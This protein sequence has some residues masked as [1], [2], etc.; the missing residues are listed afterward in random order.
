MKREPTRVVILNVGDQ[1]Y[2]QNDLAKVIT[3]FRAGVRSL[4]SANVVCECTVMNDDDAD[5]TAREVAGKHFDAFIVDYVSWHITPY[6]MRTL[7]DY[8]DVP[9]L[10]YG[11]GGWTDGT[12]KLIAPAAA[13][14]TTALTPVLKEFGFK[15]T[16]VNEKPD[17]GLKL[18][19]ID[20]FLRVVG[21]VK[22]VRH[23]RIG[24]Y[25]YAD[26]GLFSCS[27]NKTLALKKLGVDI[28]DYLAYDLVDQMNGYSKEEVDQTVRE[29]LSMTVCENTVKPEAIEKVAR[30]YLAMKDKK[31]GR[32]LDAVSIKCVFG[33]TQMGFNPC[34]AQ[35]LLADKDTSVICE[36]D[37]YGMLTGII[38]SRVSGKASAFVEHY[39][40]FDDSVL[41]GVCGFIPRDFIEGD[42]KIRSANL[43]EFNTG[44]S[45]VSKMKTGACTFARLCEQNGEYKLFLGKGE[46]MP[47]PKWTEHGWADPTPDFPSVTLHPD[48]PMKHYLDVVPGQHIV[49]I[50]GDWVEDLELFCK[51]MDIEVIR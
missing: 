6:V 17:E 45:N 29:I 49:M 37:A 7:K 20:R 35:S 51:F 4:E 11:S 16:L 36:C 24:L 3:N 48:T 26:M 14:G 50:Y 43:G 42:F 46:A 30:L 23:S 33:V 25:G 19:E 22:A 34:L 41:V 10:V 8:P 47:N 12:G 28:E 44:I 1:Q 9:I 15:Y 31:N 18:D 32:G 39:E 13:A 27:Y 5:M 40:V 2:P 21:A 38:L